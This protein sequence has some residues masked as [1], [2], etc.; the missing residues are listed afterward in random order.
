MGVIGLAQRSLCGLNREKFSCNLKRFNVLGCD[1]KIFKTRMMDDKKQTTERF[2]KV[3]NELMATKLIVPYALKIY[4]VINCFTQHSPDNCFKGSN[5]YLSIVAGINEKTVKKKIK[6]LLDKPWILTNGYQ[7]EL[8]R[9]QAIDRKSTRLN[10]SHVR[11]SYAVFC[12]KKKKKIDN[13][14]ALLLSQIRRGITID[15]T[16]DIFAFYYPHLHFYGD[17]SSNILK[18]G[19]HSTPLSQLNT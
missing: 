10:S 16:L 8:R 14:G 18:N 9:L 11:I 3:P 15:S 2:F 17:Q 4:A 1:F 6:L 5:K 13:N 12:L 7:N 19:F